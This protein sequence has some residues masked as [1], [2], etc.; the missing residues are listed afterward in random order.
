MPERWGL[1]E[2]VEVYGIRVVGHK[3]GRKNRQ[4]KHQNEYGSRYLTG[5]V[6]AL[7]PVDQH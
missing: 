4:E 5:Q 2:T 3:L 7:L 1:F 6:H